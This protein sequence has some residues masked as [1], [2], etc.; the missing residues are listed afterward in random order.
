MRGP[1]VVKSLDSPS[2][3]NQRRADASGVDQ[4]TII[5]GSITS[6]TAAPEVGVQVTS[7][8]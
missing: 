3:R 1:S 7:M 8:L 5:S 4:T 6:R 2:P